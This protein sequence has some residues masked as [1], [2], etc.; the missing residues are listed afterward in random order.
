MPGVGSIPTVDNTSVSPASEHLDRA[1][2]SEAERSKKVYLTGHLKKLG[3][4]A[5]GKFCETPL[6]NF[7]GQTRYFELHTGSLYWREPD[8]PE[9]VAKREIPTGR[10]AQC[11]WDAP[12]TAWCGSFYH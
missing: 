9:N 4:S 5:L 3:Q 12:M 6:G 1:R 10:I 11:R 7:L 8:A 2:D